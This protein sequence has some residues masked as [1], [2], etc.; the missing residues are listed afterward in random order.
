MVLIEVQRSAFSKVHVGSCG[1]AARLEQAWPFTWLSSAINPLRHLCPGSVIETQVSSLKRLYSFL[2]CWECLERERTK[3]ET[4]SNWDI[5][6]STGN[7]DITMAI[8]HV[9]NGHDSQVVQQ[10][11]VTIYGTLSLQITVKSY[12]SLC[13]MLI[14]WHCS[15]HY[16][17]CNDTYLSW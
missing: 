10:Y 4:H 17:R 1:Y 8:F 11:H 14:K 5:C 12:N 2:S 3:Q 9:I 7:T 6:E 15:N 16:K 13:H